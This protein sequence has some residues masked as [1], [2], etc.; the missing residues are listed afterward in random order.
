MLAR[1]Q[2]LFLKAAASFR[3]EKGQGL[4]EYALILALVSV[5]LAGALTLLALVLTGGYNDV[6]A[7]F[8]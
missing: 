8:P 2:R 7:A 1:A 5:A 4:T 3:G 6:I